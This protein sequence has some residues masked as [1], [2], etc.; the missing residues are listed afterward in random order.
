VRKSPRDSGNQNESSYDQMHMSA[1][2]YS[3]GSSNERPVVTSG[4]VADRASRRWRA[5][6]RVHFYSGMIAMPFILLMAVTGLVILYTQPIQDLTEGDLRTVTDTG[7]WISFDQMAQSVE[8]AYP[9]SLVVSLTMPTDG[10]HSAIFGLD[11]GHQAY[12][13]P[14]TGDVLGENSAGGGVVGL[15]NRLHGYLNNEQRMV[16]LPTVSAL[17]DDGP[18][19][20]DYVIGDLLLE[21]MGVWVIVLAASGIYLWGPR[22]SRNAGA[23]K[24]GRTLFGV[25]LGKRGRAKWRDLHAL[26][27]VLMSITLLVTLVSGMAWST[28]WGTNFGA[29]ANEIS[30]NVWV[31]APASSLGTRGDLDVL[32]N[33]IPWNTGDIPIPAS[34]ATEPTGELP[35]PVTLDTVVAIGEAEGM[36]PGFA[37]YFPDNSTVDDAGNPVYGSFTLSNSWPRKTGEARDLFLDQFSGETIDEMNVYGYGSVSYAMDTAVSWHMGTQWGIVTRIFMTLLCVLSIWAV[38]S[39]FVMFWKRRRPGTAGLPRRPRDV[40]FGWGLWAIIGVIAIVY[41]LWGVTA[42]VILLLDRFVIRSV[43]KLRRAFGQR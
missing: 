5:I 17:W 11:D 15:S 24:N 22:K 21:I 40:K 28:Y 23:E 29:L 10:E 27:G 39:G 13:N 7:E 18:V 37:I 19:M 14:Y 4:D 42:A 25:R 36:K 33:T 8:A 6:W 26:G 30:P 16:S 3:D 9:E 35:A 2:T 34:Y 38:V 20:R 41:P 32:G 31:D 12:V 1:V 43:P